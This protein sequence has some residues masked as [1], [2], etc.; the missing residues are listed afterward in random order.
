[1]LFLPTVFDATAALSCLKHSA[2]RGRP[3]GD[4]CKIDEELTRIVEDWFLEKPAAQLDALPVECEASSTT[5]GKHATKV[6]NAFK[7]RQWIADANYG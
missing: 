6:M 7:L 2:G 5:R 4:R 3:C 1:M